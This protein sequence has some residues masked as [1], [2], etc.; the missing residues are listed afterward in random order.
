M[1]FDREFA[2]QYVSDNSKV[3]YNQRLDYQY[4][5]SMDNKTLEFYMRL[6]KSFIRDFPDDFKEV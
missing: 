4:I 6:I 3:I 2:M 5:T 1:G